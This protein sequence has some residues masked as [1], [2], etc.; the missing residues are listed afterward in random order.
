M[1]LI[2]YYIHNLT[3]TATAVTLV[4]TSLLYWLKVG[5][6]SCI[7]G[8]VKAIH[9]LEIII[10]IELVISVSCLLYYIGELYVIIITFLFICCVFYYNI[11]IFDHIR[12][13]YLSN[14]TMI[15]MSFLPPGKYYVVGSYRCMSYNNVVL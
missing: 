4:Y 1:I 11:T 2:G 15:P 14:N 12:I 3:Y 6:Y 9:I 13:L 5:R 7:I 8:E 10:G